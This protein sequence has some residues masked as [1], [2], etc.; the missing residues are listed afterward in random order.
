M[1]RA[2]AAAGRNTKNAAEKTY[3]PDLAKKNGEAGLPVPVLTITQILTFLPVFR[4][5]MGDPK[6]FLKNS[7]FLLDKFDKCRI[8]STRIE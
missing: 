7:I 4:R 2:H 1:N 3:S 5:K 8:Y 6:Y